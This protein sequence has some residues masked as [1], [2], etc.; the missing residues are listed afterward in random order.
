[1]THAPMAAY[2]NI[3]P[4]V[5]HQPDCPTVVLAAAELAKH[6]STTW[7]GIPKTISAASTAKDHALAA[8]DAVAPHALAMF[9]GS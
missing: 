7:I 9:S 4:A 8:P 3:V 5:L 1:M 6:A 2:R